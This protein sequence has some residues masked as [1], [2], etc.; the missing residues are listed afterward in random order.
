MTSELE[1]ILGGSYLA[2]IESAPIESV[3]A[4]RAECQGVETGLSYLRR[5]A[6][7]RLDV[8]AAELRRRGEGA[9]A[10]DLAQLVSDLPETLSDHTRNPGAGRLSP[11]LDPGD[12]DPDLTAELD[13]A[14]SGSDID[15]LPTLDDGAIAAA[16]A[17]VEDVEHR[18]SATRRDVLDRVDALQAEL[19][20]RYRTGEASVE[21]L[22]R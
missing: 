6:Q 12:A 19:T 21:S 2:G 10:S 16:L 3:R 8:M 22:L 9:A 4:K 11:T 15:S 18:I 14:V 1:R 17:R 20:R 7:G 13:E 5:L